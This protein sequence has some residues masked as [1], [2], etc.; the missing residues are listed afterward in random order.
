[1]GA[2]VTG[3]SLPAEEISLFRQARI[4]EVVTHIE[5]DIRDPAQV[6]AAFAAADP[7][8]VFH[9]AA[10]PLVRL[11]YETPVETYATMCRARFTCSTPVA[12][13]GRW[14]WMG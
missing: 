3:L 11:S 9:L 10:Q 5:G 1:M 14:G 12:V 2:K 7:E 13:R 4:E 6:D 8:V